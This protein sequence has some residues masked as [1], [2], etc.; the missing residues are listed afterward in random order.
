[1]RIRFGS[2]KYRLYELGRM[3]IE[4]NTFSVSRVNGDAEYALH[5]DDKTGHLTFDYAVWVN[6]GGRE[7]RIGFYSDGN[8][9]YSFTR[10]VLDCSDEMIEKILLD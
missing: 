6:T 9:H 3:A 2:S 7:N 8:M 10:D 4:A 1:M 5:A